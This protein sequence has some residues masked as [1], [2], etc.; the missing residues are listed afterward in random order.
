MITAPGDMVVY[1]AGSPP[2]YGRYLERNRGT[3]SRSSSSAPPLFALIRS[4]PAGAPRASASAS[5]AVSRSCNTGLILVS[6]CAPA[7]ERETL[8]VVRLSSRTPRFCSSPSNAWL[9]AERET[10]MA[11]AALRKLRCSATAAKAA[12]AMANCNA[13]LYSPNILNWDHHY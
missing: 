11:S 7:S 2:I 8:R 9:R 1:C 3:T 4:F 13:Y 6:R 10:P 5:S 12:R